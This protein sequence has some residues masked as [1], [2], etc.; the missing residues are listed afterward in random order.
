DKVTLTYNELIPDTVVVANNSSMGKIFTEN[1]DFTVD[2]DQGVIIR[3]TA[4][5]IETSAEVYIWYQHYKVYSRD[6]DYT[7]NY[8][9][10]YITRLAS[11]DIEAG[12]LVYIDYQSLY[13]NITDEAINN[14]ILEASSK[15]R[16]I[17]DPEYES[18]TD[19]ALITSETY[20]TLAIICKI[21]AIEAAG[22]LT[23]S[24]SGYRG[25]FWLQLSTSYYSESM[26][27]LIPYSLKTNPLSSPKITK[28]S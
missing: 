15:I 22:N 11:G 13:G 3:I 8:N 17:I 26:Q 20:S 16:A 24:S 19:Q 5:A 6:V 14:A 21:K 18:S 27:M 25:D 12:Q 7:I 10:G 28:S 2:Y 4:G 1:I 23:I 9:N